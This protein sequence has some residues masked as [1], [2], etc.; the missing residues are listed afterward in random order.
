MNITEFA[1]IAGVS[2]S[3]VSRFFNG[4]Y[5]AEDKKALIAA[6]VE[7]TG[8]HPSA[9]AQ[10][11]RTRQTRQIGVILPR[12]SSESCSR[13]VEGI[14]DVLDEQNYHLL[15]VNTANTPAREVEALELFRHSRVDGVIFL[16]S[17]FTPAHKS[18]L[19]GMHLPVVIVGQRYEGFN[20]VCHDDTGAARALTALMLERGSRCP[21]Y[22]GVTLHDHAAGYCRRQGFIDALKDAGIAPRPER[23]C[24]AQFNMES[25][26]EQAAA[27][28]EK[29]PGIDCLFCATDSIALGAMHYCRAHQVRIPGDL[30]LAGVGDNVA[31][32]TAAVPLTSAHLHY[33]TSGRTAAELL[34]EMLRGE[35]KGARTI[36]LDYT[37]QERLSTGRP[38]AELKLYW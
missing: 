4:G 8:Y 9:Q 27:L 35:K 23:M 24:L 32:R 5:L 18:V 14:S 26:Y 33:R 20:C 2:K 1:Q 30:L 31:G 21:G 16:A 3:A 25:G 34:L 10:T 11:L 13:V 12:L 15:L 19:A 29:S 28:F 36:E 17:V 7:K 22:L 37:L 6:A 38:D